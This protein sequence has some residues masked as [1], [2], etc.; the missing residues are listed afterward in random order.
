MNL[1]FKV[2]TP[3]LNIR[4]NPT[5]YARI[6][7]TL[8]SGALIAS[9]ASGE[10]KIV[11]RYLWRQVQE[12]GWFAVGQV[13]NQNDLILCNQLA[14]FQGVQ[15]LDNHPY[16]VTN[17]ELF[18]SGQLFTWQQ[19]DIADTTNWL[20]QAHWIRVDGSIEVHLFVN[21]LGFDRVEIE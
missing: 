15:G 14:T 9:P 5:I 4:S 8:P 21:Q 16:Q 17:T 12:G 6:L 10:T 13:D 2:R 1:I 3:T 7:R 11:N 18:N 19:L 20:I